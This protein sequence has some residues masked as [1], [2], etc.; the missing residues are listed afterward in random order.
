MTKKSD[1]PW[2]YQQIELGY[3]YRMTEA[4]QSSLLADP[5]IPDEVKVHIESIV[6]TNTPNPELYYAICWIKYDEHSNSS[7]I[8]EGLISGG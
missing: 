7:L 8:M 3:N 6:T 1:G 4:I 5:N 2:Y